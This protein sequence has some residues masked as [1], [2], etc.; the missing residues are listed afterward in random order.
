MPAANAYSFVLMS[1]GG[2]ASILLGWISNYGRLAWKIGIMLE[3]AF[4]VR[5]TRNMSLN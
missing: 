2:I 5:L 1:M 4:P 3:M